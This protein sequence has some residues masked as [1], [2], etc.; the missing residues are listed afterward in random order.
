MIFIDV[1]KKKYK[2]K[3]KLLLKHILN[4]TKYSNFFGNYIIIN[5]N[6]KLVNNIIY[7]K[8]LNYI[9]KDYNYYINNTDINM[10]NVI[11][12][13]EIIVKNQMNNNFIKYIK[14]YDYKSRILIIA[15]FNFEKS[16]I[17][18]LINKFK[19]VD[20]LCLNNSIKILNIIE[21][22]NNEYGCNI[23]MING[24]NL[25]NYDIYVIIH[26]IDLQKYK[27]NY[28][29]KYLDLNDYDNDIYTLEYKLYKKYEDEFVKVKE[30]S[31]QK[32]GRM[33]AIKGGKNNE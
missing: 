31:K 11:N 24:E 19:I 3:D 33:I 1:I 15:K 9:L 7:K 30:F 14:N 2:F 4:Y 23:N 25:Q 18:K 8:I 16:I 12:K 13:E 21:E 29:V 28:K 27:I 6:R 22:L 17:T 32:I 26:N 10:S 20:I 5:I